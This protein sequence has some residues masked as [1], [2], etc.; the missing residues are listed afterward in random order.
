LAQCYNHQHDN[1][2]VWKMM[3]DV[4]VVFREAFSS[5]PSIHPSVLSSI[6]GWHHTRKKTLAEINKP[7][8][9]AHASMSRKGMPG[10]RGGAP[11]RFW[12]QYQ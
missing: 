7:P 2:H 4:V 8:P 5:D 11:P 3:K 1:R 6:H 9:F 10:P 12:Y